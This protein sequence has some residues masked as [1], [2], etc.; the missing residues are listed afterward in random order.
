MLDVVLRGGTVVDGTGAAAWRADVGVRRGLIVAIGDVDEPASRTV[1]AD[2]LVVAPGFID[3]HTHYDV[4]VLWDP[5]VS[6]SPLHGVTT[7]VGGNCGFS[8]APLEPDDVDYVM[9]MMARVEGMPLD[10]LQAGPAWDWR[11]F[12]EWLGRLDG[13]LAIN[14][15]FL[16]GHSTLRRLAM[17]EAAVG[18][19]ATRDQ[20]DRMVGMAHDAMASGALGFSSSLGEAH[21]DGDGRPV[22]S[23]AARAEEFLALAGTLRDHAGT[24]LEFIAAMGE[25]PQER[26]ELMAQMSL[27]AN[28]PLNWNLLGSLSSVEVYQQQLTAC[29]WATERGATV[30]ALA[31]PD[32]LRM[33]ANSLVE[34]LPG[35]R[36]VIELSDGA[37]RSAV[38]DPRVRQRL[39]DGLE[40]AARSG[41]QV[42]GQW[43]LV[44]IAESTAP[45]KTGCTGRTIT[46]VAAERGT[47]PI[48]VLIDVVLLDQLPLTMVF[49]S[50]TPSLGASDA[51][52]QVR[53]KVWKDDRVVLGGSDAG[54]H[55]DVMCH[56]NYTTV[57]LG[58]LVRERALFTLEEAV[59]ELTE[60]PA[61]LYGLGRRGRVAEGWHADLV[62][63]DPERV[64]S[65]PAQARCDLP[66]GASRLYAESRGVEHVLVG[67]REVVEGGR[68]T[69]ELAGTL[70]RSGVD[71]ETVTVPGGGR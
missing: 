27:A 25:I 17:G 23:R 71:T 46:D 66:G 40:Q 26:I 67:G 14:A 65:D 35:W 70:L 63:F 56:A 61:R 64:G 7:I 53:A 2:G 33:R 59:R 13:H 5:T 34:T 51:G 49:P 4:Q 11:S 48:D 44:E 3:I 28:R 36:E 47:E 37:R 55:L 42:I 18:E 24:S 60:V 62:V 12:G 8:V 69:G 54:A 22:P 41:L 39:R 19:A 31:L 6:P 10:A 57:V 68:M 52:W 32:L 15:G 43:D 20:I 1:D 9:R 16:V 45:D 50:L 58:H 30:K 21:T 38:H 29:D